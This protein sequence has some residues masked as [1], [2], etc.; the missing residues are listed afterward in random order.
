M[1]VCSRTEKKVICTW[2]RY[3]RGR[4]IMSQQP[5]FHP[6]S[7]S[8]LLAVHLRFPTLWLL[9]FHLYEIKKRRRVVEAKPSLILRKQYL[10]IILIMWAQSFW[11]SNIVKSYEE[12]LSNITFL[13]MARNVCRSKCNWIEIRLYIKGYNFGNLLIL[14]K[15]RHFHLSMKFKSGCSL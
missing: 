10:I 6:I 2:I 13:I 3:V 9:Y 14:G 12:T 5:S 7:I 8:N 4:Y 1:V 11:E 15:T